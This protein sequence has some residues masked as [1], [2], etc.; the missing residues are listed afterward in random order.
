MTFQC[1]LMALLMLG[2]FGAAIVAAKDP[3]CE[4]S[5]VGL[6]RRTSPTQSAHAGDPMDRIFQLRVD[7]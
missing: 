5:Y 1:R 6:D 4:V 3:G 7:L 2:I